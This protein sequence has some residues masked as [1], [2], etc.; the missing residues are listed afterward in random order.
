MSEPS[1]PLAARLD[2]SAL[3]GD[4]ETIRALLAEAGR[5]LDDDPSDADAWLAKA[6]AEKL[7][8]E[9][10]RSEGSLRR[11]LSLEPGHL[12]AL[13][14][15]AEIILS[16]QR[17]R[18]AV[19]LLDQ[20]NERGVASQA[21]SCLRARAYLDIG[22]FET[23]ERIA[24]EARDENPDNETAG[25]VFASVLRERG[26]LAEAEAL[27][28]EL[29]DNTTATR[30]AHWLLAQI[31]MLRGDKENGYRNMVTHFAKLS[32]RP[33]PAVLNGI[34]FWRG[35]PLAGETLFVHQGELNGDTIQFARYIPPLASEGANVILECP[36]PLWPFFK[37]LKGL[38]GIVPTGAA[39]AA[40]YR[41]E[42]MSLPALHSLSKR[43]MPPNEPRITPEE[44]RVEHAFRRLN[45]F[46][47]PW[48]GIFPG[49]DLAD[50]PSALSGVPN[51]ALTPLLDVEG[52]QFIAIGAAW[53]DPR[54]L[55]LTSELRPGPHYFPKLSAFLHNFDLVI[56]VD[57][58][59]NQIAGALGRPTWLMLRHAPDWRW[60]MEGAADAWYPHH[61]L[62]RQPGPGD[63]N[64]MVE[65]LRGALEAFADDFREPGR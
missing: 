45:A 65:N 10:T 1:S 6:R 11:V 63:W 32:V 3:P 18:E 35:E 61:R 41:T 23:A 40:D 28:R 27:V 24:C 58:A 47:R 30:E 31:Q 37:N 33:G 26:N 53:H 21:L 13:P 12:E 54:L 2:G 52:P 22:D 60:G 51:E 17:P 59:S 9:R 38:S 57:T 7:L 42:I 49:G 50:P 29:I 34:P 39:V 14:A 56:T 20:A 5:R 43:P 19:T 25:L 64:G 55:N 46:Q 36:R 8:G 15:L 4:E 62:F 48:V 44:G 16:D